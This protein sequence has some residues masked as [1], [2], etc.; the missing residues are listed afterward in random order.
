[1]LNRWLCL[2][3]GACGHTQLCAPHASTGSSLSSH[4]LAGIGDTNSSGRHELS[5]TVTCEVHRETQ[6]AART[7]GHNTGQP[8]SPG[9]L[10]SSKQKGLLRGS[11][12]PGQRLLSIEAMKMEAVQRPCEAVVAD[13]LVI[14]GMNI[15]AGD[16][17][18]TFEG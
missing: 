18:L 6:C 4:V 1:M 5:Q 3:G 7:G 16:L 15:E 12:R 13:V 2:L 10:V 8:E 17:L 14:A 9:L 11:R